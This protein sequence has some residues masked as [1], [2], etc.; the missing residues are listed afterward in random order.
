MPN[1]DDD[2]DKPWT[3]K[4]LSMRIGFGELAVAVIE[5]W[6]RDGRPSSDREAM[7]YWFSVKQAFDAKKS[8]VK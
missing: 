4:E 3:R 6:I 8:E 2:N 5:Q 7:E 1:T